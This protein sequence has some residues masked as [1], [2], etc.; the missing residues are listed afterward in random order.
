[1]AAITTS[2]KIS[3]QEANNLISKAQRQPG[4]FWRDVLGFIPW[5]KQWEILRS[6]WLNQK[7]AVRSCHGIGKSASAA[8][9][10]ITF[11]SAYPGSVVITTAPTGRQVKMILWQEWRKA[12]NGSKHKL[13]GKLL[14]VSHTYDDGW[15]AFG[16][17]TDVPDNFQGLHANRILIIVDEAAGIEPKIADAVDSLMT[18]E[19]SRLLTI[20]NPTDPTGWFA[21]LF[22][23]PDVKKIHVSAF[24]SPNF[25]A[26]G[27]T[28]EDI[29]EG[30]WQE[31]ITGPL[32]FP[33]LVTPEWVAGRYKKWGP[34]SPAYVARVKGDFPEVG[35][36]V[37]IPLTWIE[38]AMERWKEMEEGEPRE[39]GCDI[40]RFGGDENVI[41]YRAG[42]K[43]TE[44]D[45][46]RKQDLMETAG[47]IKAGIEKHGAT[48]A[49]IDTIGYGAGVYDRLNE[50]GESVDEV[51]VGRSA[52]DKEHYAD[53]GSELW[54]NVRDAL[55]PKGEDPIGLPP[56]DE[57]LGQ[58]A[59][60]RYT[61]TSRGQ[62][63]IEPK[64]DMKK[65]GLNSPD[66]GDAVALAFAP[67]TRA[68]AVA[69]IILGEGRS[70]WRGM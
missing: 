21:G 57:L 58:L 34:T 65:R 43:V 44:L 23:D 22:K 15:Y 51:E 14:Q 66:R 52:I 2:T 40:A 48:L 50:L 36:N 28:E 59:D 13:G 30:T 60:R 35:D 3:P 37:I 29:A 27:I 16:F 68:V 53:L 8:R 38:L 46:W 17:A 12:V 18:S 33:A 26:F 62:I 69:P 39:L 31:K 19:N 42:R 47:R 63:K 5:R 11:L 67:S 32:P 41:A 4:W 70:K 10:G 61:Y 56:D 20:G 9:I 45:G 24:D 54:F 6:V 49:K 55:D 7:T 1:M 64:E 25:T